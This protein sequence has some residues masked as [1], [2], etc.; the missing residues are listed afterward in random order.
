[1][2]AA[3]RLRGRGQARPPPEWLPTNWPRASLRP[4][5]LSPARPQTNLGSTTSFAGLLPPSLPL[6]EA[7]A[8][9]LA[10][11]VRPAPRSRLHPPSNLPTRS[12]DEERFRLR[13]LDTDTSCPSRGTENIA[14]LLL[15]RTLVVRPPAP[16]PTA[17]RA[18]R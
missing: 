14:P 3:P 13:S 10:L 6:V 18:P 11:R 15:Q 16:T 2:A 1:M 4:N 12:Q 9:L 17:A 5:H 7:R 8:L